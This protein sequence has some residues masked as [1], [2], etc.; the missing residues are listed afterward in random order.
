V[1]GGWVSLVLGSE[2]RKRKT[3]PQRVGVGEGGLWWSTDGQDG[4][5]SE[6]HGRLAERASGGGAVGGHNTGE[7]LLA[8]GVGDATEP[9]IA[10]RWV[11]V[12]GFWTFGILSY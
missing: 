10:D 5:K 4:S 8:A 12:V 2:R 7:S 6:R 1:T 9:L 3:E 11:R